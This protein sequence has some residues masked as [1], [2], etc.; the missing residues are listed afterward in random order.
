MKLPDQENKWTKY[1]F[2]QFIFVECAWVRTEKS[3]KMFTVAWQ[4]SWRWNPSNTD[5][6][7]CMKNVCGN[8][9]KGTKIGTGWQ[10]KFLKNVD[11]IFIW[12]FIKNFSQP[13]NET[14]SNFYSFFFVLGKLNENRTEIIKEFFFRCGIFQRLTN[15]ILHSTIKKERKIEKH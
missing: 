10:R 13:S 1:L 15:I 5:E 2:F 7:S 11:K 14:P 3:C 9:K 12:I 8:E 4:R 6:N